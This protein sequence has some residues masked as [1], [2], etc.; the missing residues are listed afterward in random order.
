MGVFN[1]KARRVAH[2]HL[3]P[4]HSGI[5]HFRFILK[6]ARYVLKLTY[7][8]TVPEYCPQKKTVRVR[9]NRTTHSG[10]GPICGVY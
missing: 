4:G 10:F 3:C 5:R 8:K 7:D 6:P 9:A 1:G 2:R